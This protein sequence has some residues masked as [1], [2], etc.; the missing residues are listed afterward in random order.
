MED[1]DYKKLFIDIY[2]KNIK[3]DGAKEL[4]DFLEKSDFFLVP[5]SSQFH[6][7]FQGGLCFHSVN[8]YNRFLNIIKSEFGE[9]YKD[10]VEYSL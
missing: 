1:I 8:V 9:N 10:K 7:N 3:R 6:S 4:L 5:A 2:T